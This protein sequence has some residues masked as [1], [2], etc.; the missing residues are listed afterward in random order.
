MAVLAPSTQP[1]AE[2]YGIVKVLGQ[3]LPLVQ[4]R[5]TAGS[6]PEVKNN[7]IVTIG[8]TTKM[9]VVAAHLY[10]ELAGNVTPRIRHSSMTRAE[11]SI[12]AMQQLGEQTGIETTLR[13]V[14]IQ[15]TDLNRLAHDAVHRPGCLAITRVKSRVPTRARSTRLPYKTA[16]RKKSSSKALRRSVADTCIQCPARSSRS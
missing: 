9:G 6:A 8:A 11:G 10:A 13:Q 14:A 1:L 5:T 4:V 12:V 3:R 7:A 15:E 16:G 2:I